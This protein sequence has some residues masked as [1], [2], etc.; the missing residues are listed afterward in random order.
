MLY[1]IKHKAI[2]H[3]R[4]WCITKSTVKG[5]RAYLFNHPQTRQGQDKICCNVIKSF[6]L[7]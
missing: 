1:I 6:H 2:N 4:Q 5:N 3:W 7:L